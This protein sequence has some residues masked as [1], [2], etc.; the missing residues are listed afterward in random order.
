MKSFLWD[1]QSTGWL[2]LLVV[3]AL[4]A[5]EGSSGN[6]PVDVVAAVDTLETE[7]D[8]AE[9]QTDVVADVDLPY[10]PGELHFVEE[11]GDD[12]VS[13][14]DAD[15][16]RV[17]FE[18][19]DVRPLPVRYTQS[20]EPAEGATIR[21]R[22]VDDENGWVALDPSSGLDETDAEGVAA[23]LRVRFGLPTPTN[24]DPCLG[25]GDIFVE[26][27]VEGE[28]DVTPIR[29]LLSVRTECLPPLIIFPDYQGT[30]L[31]D[32]VL[33]WLHE[34]VP[35]PG[36]SGTY[37]TMNS[38]G[39][40]VSCTALEGF[41]RRGESEDL[42]DALLS[43]SVDLGRSAH[44]EEAVFDAVAPDASEQMYTVFVVGWDSGGEDIIIGCDD[45]T[46]LVRTHQT[47]PVSRQVF[48]SMED[49]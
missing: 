12:G 35:D 7:A 24:P 42:P 18:G 2:P 41:V 23:G 26:V 34:Q 8:V 16:C 6:D 27:A 40:D 31:V 9:P 1:R 48:V 22:V 5:C 44:F 14:Q 46:A 43:A 29:F 28:P 38:H 32:G 11:M 39:D 4:A 19:P 20:G 37:L 25:S 30:L 3:L 21:Y 47:T 33:I 45:T 13:C 36:T 49:L 17:F 15:Q 10:I